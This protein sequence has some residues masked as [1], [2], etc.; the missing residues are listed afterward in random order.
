MGFFA[1]APLF[2]ATPVGIRGGLALPPFTIGVIMIAFRVGNYGMFQMLFTARANERFGERRVFCSAVLPCIATFPTIRWIVQAQKEVGLAILVLIFTQ[3]LWVVVD[4]AYV[5]IFV[6]VTGASPN[7]Y[8]L[9]TMNGLS[10]T[11]T[12][13]VRAMGPAAFTSLLAFSKEYNLLRGNHVYVA[14]L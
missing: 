6:F 5:V 1:L 14:L 4:M 8:S 2:Y 12:S 3:L 10:Q 7:K 9:G 11:T 13:I